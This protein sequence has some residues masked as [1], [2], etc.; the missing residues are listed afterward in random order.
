MADNPFAVLGAALGGDSELE[1]E[2]GRAMGAKTEEALAAARERVEKNAARQRLRQTATAAG[3]PEADADLY[4]DVLTSGGNLGDLFGGLRSK[5][6]IDLRGR[7]SNPELPFDQRNIALQGVASAPVSRFDTV[8]KGHYQD[9]FSNEAPIDLGG[10][11]GDSGGGDAAGIQMLRAFGF[12]DENGRVA[13][14]READ[15]F[16]LYRDTTRNVDVGGVPVQTFNNPFRRG[17]PAQVAPPSA[18]PS[19]AAPAVTRSAVAAPS[20]V[21]ANTATVAAAKERGSASGRAAAGLPST[22]NTIDK[23]DSDIDAFL[24]KPGFNYV[25]GNLQG[26]APGRIISGLA[27]Q[28]AADAQ[29]AFGN[30]GSQAFLSS[31][32]KMRGFGQLS[33]Q[34][35]LKVESALTRATNPQ[36]SE[37]DARVAWAEVKTHL[38]ELKRVAEIE[39]NMGSA[40]PAGDVPAGP[41]SLDEYLKSKGF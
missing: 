29:A 39:A 34:E 28:D 20:E 9:K 30:L 4:A 40:P 13:P 17:A 19:A 36:L 33:N 41:V 25:Y 8:G 11:F 15:A 10:A 12:M 1:Y 26:T 16:D 5:Q 27:S 3:I 32:Q 14:G 37:A 24:K 31:I 38:A 22:F 21:A 18:A 6:E 23:F 35:G 2:Q 7:A